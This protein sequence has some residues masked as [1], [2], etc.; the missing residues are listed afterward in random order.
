M[1]E[2]NLAVTYLRAKDNKAIGNQRQKLNE[3]AE[4]E[5]FRIAG[6]YVDGCE[7]GD[8]EE[9]PN[10]AKLVDDSKHGNWKVLLCLDLARLGRNQSVEQTILLQKLND[11]G[12]KLHTIAEGEVRCE[13]LSQRLID[14]M[15]GEF[16]LEQS[17]L[18][19]ELVRIGKRMARERKESNL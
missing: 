13:S 18:H 8:E 11:A 2:E 4:R 10:L 16:L 17:K 19:G 1:S 12:V 14:L 7:P 3:Y 9:Q 5:G 6:S 15:R